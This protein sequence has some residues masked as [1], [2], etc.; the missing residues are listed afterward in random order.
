MQTIVFVE[1]KLNKV[2]EIE[3]RVN[4]ELGLR[5]LY[6]LHHVRLIAEFLEVTSSS[7]LHSVTKEKEVPEVVKAST[8]GAK[9]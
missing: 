7:G 8:I 5:C 4:A 9:V 2:M 3:A 6:V 1:K